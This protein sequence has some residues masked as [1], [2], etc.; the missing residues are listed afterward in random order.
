MTTNRLLR[1]IGLKDV[2]IDDAFWSPRLEINRRVTIPRAYELCRQTGRIDGFKLD[3]KPGRPKKPHY[4]WDSDVAKWMEAASYCL[5]TRPGDRALKRRLDHVIRL[6]AAA[7]QPDGYLNVYFTV[8]EPAKRWTNLRDWHELYCAGH[9]IEAGVAHFE[10]TGERSLLDVVARYADHIDATFGRGRGKRAGYPGHEEI[11]LAL[12][13]LYHAT[14]EQRYLNLSRYFIDERGRRPH[15]YDRE[16]RRRG[17]DPRRDWEWDYTKNQSHLPLRRQREAVGHAVRAMYV[18]SGMA[19][20]AALM[21]DASLS[22]ACR[23]L[24]DSVTA[25]KMYLTG[26]VGAVRRGEALGPD[27][28]LPAEGAYAET[29][30][31][32]GLVFFA[33]RM[34][35]SE[36]DARYADVMERPLYNGLISGVSLDGQKFFY[37]NPLASD[38]SHRRKPWYDCACCPPNLARVLA[39]LGRYAYS[40]NKR[41]IWVHLFIGGS[42]TFTVGGRPVRLEVRTRYPWDGDVCIRVIV[43]SPTRFPLM[44][45]VPGWCRRYG[46]YANGRRAA[47]PVRRGY[48][49]LRRA[50]REGDEIRLTLDMPIE[51]VHAHPNVVDAAGKVALQRGPIVYCV[52]ESDHGVDVRRLILPQRAKL[53]ARFDRRLLGGCVTVEGEAAVATGTGRKGSL[54]GRCAELRRIKLRAVPYCLWDNRAPGTM[55]VWMLQ[56]A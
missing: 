8:V 30:A 23:R 25:R 27:Y 43:E 29:C 22:R 3:W 53:D 13:R 17:E 26:G 37:E 54:Y 48:L 28:F 24:W 32:C 51:R 47:P 18:Y 19:D 46:V 5:Q 1:P 56:G 15:F 49:E 7:Q 9:L 6:V 35:Q 4:F 33:H 20:V 21:R 2:A 36:A 11:E 31:A 41:A 45:R 44:L 14:G 40:T 52:E 42:A 38:G 16:A 34:L 10:A 12:V 55:T 50:W 39:S